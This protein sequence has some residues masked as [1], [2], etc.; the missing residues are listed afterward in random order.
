MSDN[1]L[2][3]ILQAI[4]ADKFAKQIGK[5]NAQLQSFGADAKDVGQKLSLGLSAPI[6]IAGVKALSSAAKFEKLQTQL[7]VLTGSTKKGTEAFKQLV[8]FSAGTPFQL[9]ELVQANNTLMGFGVSAGD[10]FKHLQSIGDIAAVSGGDLQG[11]SVAFGQVAAAGRLMGQDLL[12]LINNGVPIIDMLS[13]SM[14]VAKSEIKDMVSKGA[15]TFP[16]LIKAFQDATS[17]GGKFAGGMAMLSGTLG[18]VF[19]T[20]KDN[21]NIAFAEVG[22][23]IVESFDLIEVTK[24]IIESIQ[25]ATKAFKTFSPTTK[26]AI[27]VITALVAALGPVLLALGTLIT[28]LPAIGAAFA[29]LTGPVGLTI[30]AITAIGAAFIIFKDEIKEM[31]TF[32]KVKLA[33]AFIETI[34]FFKKIAA[35]VKGVGKI[36]GKA[37]KLE[38]GAIP[39]ILDETDAEIASINKETGEKMADNIAQ[40]YKDQL[41]KNKSDLQK[42]TENVVKSLDTSVTTAAPRQQA[43]TVSALGATAGTAMGTTQQLNLDPSSSLLGEMQTVT[44][45]P[46]AMLA[47]S[48]AGSTEELKSK[49]SAANEVLRAKGI[50][51]RIIAEEQA[52]GINEIVGGSINNL[53]VG[54]GEALGGAIATGGNL[55]N[56]LSSLLLNTVGDMAI[57]LGVLAITTG[58]GIEAIKASLKAFAGTIG[59]AAG[60]ALVAIGTAAKVGAANIGKN[61]KGGGGGGQ[62]GPRSGA[63]AAF[64][65]GGIVSGPTLGLMGEYAGAKSNPEVIAPLDKLKNMIGGGQAQQVNVGGEF[66]LNGQDLVV[67]LQRA[68]KQRGRIK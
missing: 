53:V 55:G 56:A 23:S 24:G 40:G 63:V 37:L 3:V 68:E 1:K 44:T 31:I 12:Q 33:N 48:V 59:I 39:G 25:S 6:A 49:L 29:V 65:N 61:P 36:I 67:A 11:I 51:Q 38:F 50:E 47:A 20:L 34:G 22:K 9:D 18:G 17:E 46:V 13:Q 5:A 26:K 8:K 2:R 42:A 30:M 15:V 19:S 66:R 32:L 7:N 54:L 16:V 28:L 45:D 52:A 57:R 58:K 10:A 41:E 4:G 43:T 14:G 60:I 27:V 62:S 21:I 64:A 35:R